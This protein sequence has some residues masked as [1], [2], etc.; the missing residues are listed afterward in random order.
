MASSGEAQL[1]ARRTSRGAAT[2]ERILDEA[3]AMFAEHGYAATTL[4]DVAA[5]VGVRNPSLYNHFVSKDS[6]YAA[7]LE[8]GIR[9]VFD[10]LTRWVER[11][12]RMDQRKIAL[13]MTQLLADRPALAKLIQHEVLG[14][15]GHVTPMLR[16]WLVPLLEQA[17]RMVEAGPA[18]RRW[19][20]EQLPHV[21]V[22]MYQII[23]G[24]FAAAPL[25]QE[26]S[27]R[28]PLS[29]EALAEQMRFLKAIVPRLVGPEPDRDA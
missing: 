7:V 19:R 6:L 23:V 27:G 22:A 20:P 29:K 25:Y 2:A 10:A 9:P 28:D 5:A 15:A 3:E 13:E 26:L 17:R 16:E 14:G 24:Y 18:A 1:D 4:R 12:E 8:R 11:G 21:I